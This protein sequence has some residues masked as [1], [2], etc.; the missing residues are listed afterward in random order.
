MLQTA[1]PSHLVVDAWMDTVDTTVMNKEGQ[2][3]MK[4]HSPSVIHYA[5]NDTTY[6]VSPQ[7]LLYRKSLKPWRITAG[8][9]TATHGIEHIQLASQVTLHHP[10][11]VTQSPTWINTEQLIIHPP[12]RTADTTHAVTITQP[13]TTISGIG[14]KAD[15]NTNDIRLLSNTRGD[16]AIHP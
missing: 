3:L 2:V 6:F 14:L 13:H 1:K 7:F 8:K 16:Y 4:I 11:D 5:E 9:G 15:L 10:G 12:N